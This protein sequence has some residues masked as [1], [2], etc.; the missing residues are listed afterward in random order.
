MRE[1]V[2]RE[3]THASPTQGQA[4]CGGAALNVGSPPQSL[5]TACSLA[6]HTHI[7][8][9]RVPSTAQRWI[10]LSHPLNGWLCDLGRGT[11]SVTSLTALSR[12]GSLSPCLK[13]ACHLPPTPCHLG[14]GGSPAPLREHSLPLLPAHPLPSLSHTQ[15]LI[16]NRERS[17]GRVSRGHQRDRGFLWGARSEGEVGGGGG[18]SSDALPPCCLAPTSEEAWYS[19]LPWGWNVLCVSNGLYPVLSWLFL[20]YIYFFSS[21]GILLSG[22]STSSHL[23]TSLLSPGGSESQSSVPAPTVCGVVGSPGSVP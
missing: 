9:P 15:P 22:T 18:G 4:K 3:I 6:C 5:G 21:G 7:L 16:W 13:N 11:S 12:G 23:P 8:H 14:C 1:G 17:S 10:A 2:E 19:V 20:I